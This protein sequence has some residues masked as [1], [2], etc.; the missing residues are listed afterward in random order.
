MLTK[1]Q[2]EKLV[3]F[4]D[5]NYSSTDELAE[6]LDQAIEMFFYLEEGI[7]NREDVQSVV[8]AIKRLRD[9]MRK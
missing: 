3:Q 7:F 4:L 8:F 6:H 5:Q 1:E 2:Q 9:V